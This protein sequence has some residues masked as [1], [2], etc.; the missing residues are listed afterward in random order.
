MIKKIKKCCN[1]CIFCFIDQLP[2]NLRSSLYLKDDDYL[3][4]FKHGNFITLTNLNKK[5]IENIIK[6]NLSPLYISFHSV[7]EKVRN[8][9]FGN[10][11]HK[12]SLN[13]LKILDENK[14]KTHIQIVLCPGINDGSNLLNTLN[15]LTC[16]FKN[17]LSIGIV[18]VG[19]TK[20]NKN[21]LL[22]SFN[23][24]KSKKLINIINQYKKIKSENSKIFL[25]DEFYIMADYKLPEYKYYGNFSQIENGIGLCRNFIHEIDYYLLR[26]NKKIISLIKDKQNNRY[27]EKQVKKEEN[28]NIAQ[29]IKVK[30]LILTSEYF[31]KIML[32]QIEKLK[33]FINKNN[34]N[35]NFNFK[36][37]KIKNNFFG[38]N[39]KV[40]GL[41]TYYDFIKYFNNDETYKNKNKNSYFDKILIPDIIFNNDGLTLDNKTIKDFLKISN[42]IRFVKP[43]GKSFIKEIFEI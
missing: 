12:K 31:F 15:F 14:I 23:K 32:E 21:S 5:D 37:N 30:I 19:I 20:Y 10:K 4:S 7:D 34:L 16:N 38:G 2:V 39:V 17:I 22:L 42:N 43:D 8:L 1:K 28:F 18:P 36:L 11:N 24:V 41:L 33:N 13:I 40:A 29:N 6:Y 35:L 26:Y 27:K 25:S 3:E 9:L